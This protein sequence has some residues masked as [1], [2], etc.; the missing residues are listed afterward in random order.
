M[1][2]FVHCLKGVYDYKYE[3]ITKKIFD[4]VADNNIR[5][6]G[7]DSFGGAASHA[8]VFIGKRKNNRIF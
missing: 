5:V 2:I 3:Y 7:S 8:A 6:C 4:L 1:P